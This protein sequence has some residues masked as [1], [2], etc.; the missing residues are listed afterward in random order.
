MRPFVR[1]EISNAILA[2]AATSITV[3]AGSVMYVS[4]LLSGVPN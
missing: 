3:L 2:V 4:I 1:A